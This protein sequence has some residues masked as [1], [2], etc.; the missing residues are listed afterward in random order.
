MTTDSIEV[1]DVYLHRKLVGH[2]TRLY[3]SRT[4][5]SFHPDYIQNM[6]RPTLSL[7]FKNKMGELI[8]EMPSFQRVAPPWFSNLLP[9]GI[10]RTYLSKQLDIKPHD[11]FR[12]LETLGQD[13][14]GAVT[15]KANQSST[16]HINAANI[17]HTNTELTPFRFSLAGVQ[18]KFSALDNPH[19]AGGLTIPAHGIGGSWIIKLPST[20][21]F[22]VP[23]NEYAMMTLAQKLG[24]NIPEIALIDAKDIDGIPHSLNQTIGKIFAIKRFDRNSNNTRIHIE[25]F[26]Q[27]FGVFPDNKY[28]KASY[29]LMAEIIFAEAG[30][31]DL[32]E[33]MRRLIFCTLIGNADMHLKNWSLIYPDQ[34]RAQLAPAYDLLS[35]I[36]YI[37]DNTAALKYASS[38]KMTDFSYKELIAFIEKAKLPK[39]IV[40]ETV[41]Q[42]I[43]AFRIYW[44]TEKYNTTAHSNVITAIDKH[45]ATVPIYHEV[46]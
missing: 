31:E 29:R 25:D 36:A 41:K 1:L 13:L 19:K 45:L 32:C 20:E 35:T 43:A 37:P 4:F 5:F 42:F 26:A 46:F 14:P 23:E 21:F 28:Q 22:G 16:P 44:A 33:Y 3:G 11:E 27:L 6:A 34:S 17:I 38:R 7:S 8:T 18:L 39:N 15:I 10:L 2:L 40:L 24:I 9:E 30:I 12:L